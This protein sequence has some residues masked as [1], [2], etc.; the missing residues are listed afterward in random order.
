VRKRLVPALL[1]LAFVG[2]IAGLGALSRTTDTSAQPAA[3]TTPAGGVQ[4]P[5]T[6][7]YWTM[8][9]SPS[10]DDVLLLATSKGIHR[11]ADGGRTWAAVGPKGVH[12]T[13]LAATDGELVAGGVRVAT[14][15]PVIRKGTGRTAPDGPSVLVTSTDDG[16]TWK[17]LKPRGLP[18][19]S[20]QSLA[21][22]P[23]APETLYALLNDG[24]LYRSNDGGR[25]FGL[26]TAK[27][28][29]A[30]WAIAVT[31]DG[32]FVSGDM[33]S[34]SF[35]S[36]DAKKWRNTPFKDSEGEKMVM[37]Y[38]VQPDE[39][40]KVIMS[41][42]GMMVS[43]NHGKTWRLALKSKVM[44][45]PVAYVPGSPDVAYAVGFDRSIWRSENG[46]D[47]WKKVT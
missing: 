26:A 28:G 46:G 17:P 6:P 15:N 32:T 33:D 18:A 24:R 37:E 21:S 1:V 13:S 16:E 29:I 3:T 44:F 35:V 30:P 25:S 20:I 4:V 38:A 27:L 40:R 43:S 36:A 8:I 10:D 45:G 11:S 31:N 22:D 39:G 34:G 14:P 47:T 19:A 41:S 42:M 23:R 5:Y 7:W 2:V 9:V 12:M